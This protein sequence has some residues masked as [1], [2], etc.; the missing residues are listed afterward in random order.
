MTDAEKLACEEA[1]VTI[2]NRFHKIKTLI[3][4]CEKIDPQQ[5]APVAAVAELRS[6]LDHVMRAHMVIFGQRT[7]AD[8]KSATGYSAAEYCKH[9]FDKALAHLFRAGYDA[10]DIISLSLNREIKAFLQGRSMEALFHVIPDLGQR[11]AEIEVVQDRLASI[12]ADKDVENSESELK[13]YQVY[14]ENLPILFA[15]RKLLWKHMSAVVL[16]EQE[17]RERDEVTQERAAAAEK[18][19]TKRNWW[20]AVLCLIAGGVITYGVAYLFAPH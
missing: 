1:Y 8:V 12:K 6:V 9:N 20:I 2:L 19:N 18:R 3:A 10:Y 13:Q 11:L 4:A 15:F 17:M 7:E 14:E 16:Y 5:R